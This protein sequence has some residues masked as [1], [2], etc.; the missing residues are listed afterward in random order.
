M[1]NNLRS[2]THV[3]LHAPIDKVW[4][5][6]TDPKLIKEWFFGVDTETTW[7]VGSPIVHK[8]EYQGKPYEDKGIILNFRPPITLAHSHWSPVS[9]LPDAEENYQNVTYSLFE[10]GDFTDLTVT[11]QNLPNEEAKAISD[12]SWNMVLNE[13]KEMLEEE[14]VR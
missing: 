13:L 10:R 12:Q 3:S 9:G 8:G 7:Q 1:P 6:I 14:L 2:R 11:E 5:A 4:E